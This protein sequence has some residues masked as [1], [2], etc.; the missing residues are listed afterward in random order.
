MTA[1]RQVRPITPALSVRCKLVTSHFLSVITGC[2]LVG[3]INTVLVIT[4]CQLVGTITHLTGDYMV[5]F[6]Q[7]YHTSYW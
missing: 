7:T 4:T 3:L 6:D 5:T 1:C 2:Q